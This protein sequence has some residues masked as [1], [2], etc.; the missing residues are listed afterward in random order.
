VTD[1][2]GGVLPGVSVTVTGSGLQLQ[3]TTGGG[4][5]SVQ[6]SG[7]A[8]NLV[9]KSGSNVFK[10][11]FNGTFEN[12]KMQAD[13]VTEELFTAG[14]NGFLSGNPLK[15]IQTYSIEAGRPIKKDR[16]WYWGA[17]DRQDINVGVTNFLDASLGSF[18]QDL[19]IA[20]KRASSPAPSPSP[21]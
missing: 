2:S 5:V 17:V 20:Q 10:G 16:L 11:T 6:S 3:V 21:T 1:S 7:L 18:C 14:A 8:I 9:T 13:N 19:I 15:K 4:D 12:D